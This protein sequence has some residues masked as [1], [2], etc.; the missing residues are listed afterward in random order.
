MGAMRKAL[1][2]LTTLVALA[3]CGDKTPMS[4]AEVATV[5][6]WAA[7][8]K[9]VAADMVAASEAIRADRL[10]AAQAALDRT[11]PKVAAA[12]AQVRALKTA[13][14]KRT[15]DDYM[16]I[17]R[18]TL[19]A[20]DGFVAH[21]RT[22]PKNARARLRAQQELRDANDELFTADS[23][24]RD[25]IFDHANGEQQKRLDRVIPLPSSG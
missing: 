16:R 3:G 6:R 1:I 12:E 9:P 4:D 18:R 7:A 13:G 25:R 22:D 8:Y 15:L 5:T 23:Q 20:F 17:T 21:L 19:R 14:L 24:I 11:T 2:L 10:D